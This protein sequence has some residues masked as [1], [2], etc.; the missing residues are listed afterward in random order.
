MLKE[1]TTQ[2]KQILLLLIFV[3]FSAKATFSQPAIFTAGNKTSAME[4]YASKELQRYIFQLTG[5]L[6]SLKHAAG[7]AN[8]GFVI[9]TFNNPAIAQQF[10]T[11]VLEA[12]GPEGYILQKKANTIYIA[13][14]T[15]KGCMY[16][17]YGLLEDYYQVG[18]YLGGDV[19]PAK[20]TFFLPEVNETKKPSMQIRGF[21]PWTNF[22]QSA[23]VY[24]WADW[25]FIIDQAAKM[26]FNFIHIHN[27]NGQEGHNE[28]FHN[29]TLNGITS[30]VWMPTAKTG[31]KWNSPGFDVNNYRFG[32]SDLF[33]DYDFGSDCA[34]HNETLSNDMVFRKGVSL[35]KR[36]I[37]YAHSRGIKMGLGLDI[38]LIP[39]DYNTTADDPKVIEARMKQ[40]K[41][42]YPDLDYLILFVSELINNS[43]AKL[44]L[45]KRTFDGMYSYMKQHSQFTKIAV[46]GWG[47]SKEIGASL[48][49]DVIAAPISHYSDAFEDGSIYGNREYWGCP[50]ME[51][52]FSSSQYYYP[53][54]MHLS[55]TI[56]AWKARAKNMTGFY[57]LTWRLTDAIDPKISFIAKAPWDDKNRY[58]T[59]Y[60]VYNEYA[61][62]HYGKTAALLLTE[63]INE[64]EPLSSNDAECQPTGQFT[65]K[66]P[67]QSGYLL[68]MRQFGF[69]SNDETKLLVGN[70]YTSISKAAIEKRNDADSCIA[71]VEDSAYVHFA[72]VSFKNEMDSLVYYTATA[73]PFAHLEVHID[74]LKGRM[75]AFTK[76]PET[77]GWHNWQ[78]FTTAM[79]QVSGVHDVYI[80]FRGIGKSKE[81][82]KK[83]IEQLALINTVLADTENKT[84]QQ[85]IKN[86]RARI[87]AAYQHNQLNLYFP[88]VNNPADLNSLFEP[89]V[90]NFTHRVTDISSLGN[91]QSIQNRYVQERYL[92]KE[93]EL[94]NKAAVKF[95]TQIVAKGTKDGA[96]ISWKNN[97][98]NS[99]GFHLYVNGSRFIENISPATNSAR[100]TG[101]GQLRFQVS[102]VSGNGT[103]SE[104]SPIA[105]CHAGLS[106][107]EAPHIVMVSPPSVVKQGSYF[108]VKARL[109]DNRQYNLLNATLYYRN[110]GEPTW[111]QLK[112]QQK[113][114]SV[115]TA[116]ILCRQA[117]PLE[118]Y[119]AATDGT[120]TATYP[121]NKETYLTVVVEPASI[122]LKPVMMIAKTDGKRIT[123][124]PQQ[125][126]ATSHYNIY[127]LKNKT[128]IPSTATL[129]TYLPP[130]AT[131]F[132]ANGYDL[133][134]NSLK[135]PY[136]YIITK[137]D[138][139]G[140][141]QGRTAVFA[142]TY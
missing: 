124:A 42:D 71:W 92:A 16:G 83:A 40:V 142:I 128:D 118:Y 45:W 76:V 114:K 84:H 47:L 68:N 121:A 113:V 44:A 108:S 88:L 50:W 43:P 91:V 115:F 55:N 132:E 51:R 24:N 140:I 87:E 112:M 26:R 90:K 78:P 135:G 34:L 105:L 9:G 70:R 20:K 39:P 119:I 99:K 33:D 102:A 110:I 3:V 93:K 63:I 129:L 126:P 21:L 117:L 139:H 72:N 8:Q 14:S 29:F 89:W 98:L 81:E 96:V 86:L 65:C 62:K 94:L 59:S 131:A 25:K 4:V 138:I 10:S 74:S 120:N 77:G 32:A 133:N 69:K 1:M 48:P 30:R 56:K 12:C 54:N 104:L 103:E 97:E 141:E 116:D 64:N 95:P 123:W 53:Y 19:L 136:Y 57:T 52:D 11:T 49:A 7:T 134:G 46:S 13:A 82:N 127:R 15:A 109:L 130:E 60:D 23:T 35:F 79:Q 100:V 6:L 2:H 17:V 41:E 22:P 85:N 122:I 31:H 61:V 38:D 37:A 5:T 106:D 67:E 36:V 18:F 27:Y 80:L 101:K 107:N 58:N 66:P 125:L 28:M 137:V 73:N 75:I 111:K